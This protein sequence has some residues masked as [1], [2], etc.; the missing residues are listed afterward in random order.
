MKNSNNILVVLLGCT[1]DAEFIA[2]KKV[3]EKHHHNIHIEQAPYCQYRF[4]EAMV[5][6]KIK[7]IIACTDKQYVAL[8]ECSYVNG[9]CVKEDLMSLHLTKCC[10]KPLLCHSMAGSADL[11]RESERFMVADDACFGEKKNI[12]KHVFN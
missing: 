9:Q 12:L 10:S 6:N 11:F 7:E 5:A 8:L 1:T 3:F 2:A 4:A